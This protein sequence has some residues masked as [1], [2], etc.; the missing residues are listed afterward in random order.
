MRRSLS[1]KDVDVDK[2]TGNWKSHNIRMNLLF[3]II[4]K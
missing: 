3:F 2:G 1:C 4:R